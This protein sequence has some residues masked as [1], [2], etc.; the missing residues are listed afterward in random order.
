MAVS[1]TT[2]DSN[3]PDV[4]FPYQD[5]EKNQFLAEFLQHSWRTCTIPFDEPKRKLPK[6]RGRPPSIQRPH[7]EGLD[8]GPLQGGLP[9][10]GKRS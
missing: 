6:R 3:K 10:L 2:Q 5:D 4:F 1:P 8:L 7:L 9:G